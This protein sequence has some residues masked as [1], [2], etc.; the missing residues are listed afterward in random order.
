[1][2][3]EFMVMASPASFCATFLWE[4]LSQ[5][6]ENGVS[7]TSM[8]STV[9]WAVTRPEETGTLLTL[10]RLDDKTQQTINFVVGASQL[11]NVTAC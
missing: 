6:W 1:M 11:R 5:C 9:A 3:S 8:V 2:L 10:T 7:L 4:E